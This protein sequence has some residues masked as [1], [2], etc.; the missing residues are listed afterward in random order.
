[1]PNFSANLGFLW[2]ELPLP[3]RIAAAS[4]AGFRAVELHAPYDYPAEMIA[5]ACRQHGVKLL[6]INTPAGGQPGDNGLAA[7]PGREREAMADID[8]AFD[9]AHAAGA[10]AVHVMAGRIAPE[11]KVEA[12]RV[13]G[14]ALRHAAGRAEALGLVALIEPINQR[15]IPGYFYASV[16]EAAEIV[17]EIG[18]ANLKI[19]FDFYHV[20]ILQ[21]DVIMRLRRHLAA[22][23]HVQIAAVPSRAEPDEGEIAYRA[24]FAELDALGYDGWVGCEYRPRAGTDAGLGW[25][26]ALGVRL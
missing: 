18:S 1:M 3:E 7:V 26:E 10:T 15:N 13:L 20:A 5:D 22:I 19:M 8:Q 24:I 9:Y 23:G 17:A 6:G 16:E 11:Q 14:E 12:R 25:V 2:T 4:R 21:G